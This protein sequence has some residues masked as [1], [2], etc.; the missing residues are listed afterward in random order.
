ML[1]A[2]H[3]ELT[4]ATRVDPCEMSRPEFRG[5]EQKDFSQQRRLGGQRFLDVGVGLL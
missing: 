1:M 5:L 2:T 3:R 4:S